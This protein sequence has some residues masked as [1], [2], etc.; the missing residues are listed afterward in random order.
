MLKRIAKASVWAKGAL[1]EVERR[2]WGLYKWCFPIVDLL[3]VFFGVVGWANGV[4]SVQEAASASWQ[5]S[6]SAAI[7]VTALAAFVGVA[8]PKLWAL[9]LV[10]K[11]LLISLVSMYVALYLL[12]GTLDPNVTA[13]AGLICS[14]IVFPTWRLGDLAVV[15][16]RSFK[17][18]D[19]GN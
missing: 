4:A 11:L 16:I 8:F 10:A 5:T 19:G 17:A 1:P 2:Y 13:M 9:E 12:R 14:L 6:W 3:F 15:A 18:R 7:A